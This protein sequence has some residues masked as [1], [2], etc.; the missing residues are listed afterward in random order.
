[1]SVKA[2]AM[3]VGAR[4]LSGAALEWS[5]CSQGYP[6][7]AHFWDHELSSDIRIVR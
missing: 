1:M 3:L 5:A 7:R 4:V 6:V 2:S